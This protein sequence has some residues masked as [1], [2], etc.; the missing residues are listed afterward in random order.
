MSALDALLGLIGGAVG[1]AGLAVALVGCL[2]LLRFPD[3]YTR[4]QSA[5]LVL[6][7]GAPLVVLGLAILA[8]DAALSIR[9]V[10]LALLIAMTAPL[11]AHMAASAAHGGG[12]AP[13]AGRYVA[14]RPGAAQTK[15]QA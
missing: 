14:P 3:F 8:G 15:D 13:M 9:L 12:L 10:L 1:A 4:L 5:A 7:V 11:L 2:G 6:G